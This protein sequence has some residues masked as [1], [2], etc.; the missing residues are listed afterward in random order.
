[1]VK[2][3]LG[4]TLI[5]AGC[6]L[7]ACSNVAY[8]YDQA[9]ILPPDSQTFSFAAAEL[10]SDSPVQPSTLQEAIQRELQKDGIR[11]TD[12]SAPDLLVSYQF[13]PERIQDLDPPAAGHLPN[14]ASGSAATGEAYGP[15]TG[16]TVMS[17]QIHPSDTLLKPAQ[18]TI[19]V[20]GAQNRETIWRA[21]ALMDLQEDTP[22]AER[23]ALINEVVTQM[24]E[25]FP[26]QQD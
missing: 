18:L 8:D 22:E 21:S 4:S 13:E 11:H 7:T 15:G 12:D 3:I 17:M 24:F 5:L 20:Q 6:V 14:A 10:E 16:S 2:Q 25:R 26:G 23:T 1:M 19:E 9:G